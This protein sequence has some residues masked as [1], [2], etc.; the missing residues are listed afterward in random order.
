MFPFPFFFGIPCFLPC[1]EFLVQG[2]RG[3]IGI[4]NPCFFRWIFLG[5]SKIQ[6]KEGQG[7]FWHVLVLCGAGG[8]GASFGLGGQVAI[9]PRGVSGNSDSGNTQF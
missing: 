9:Q 6:A 8:G 5:F 7:F 3:S 2:F 1:E 4:K